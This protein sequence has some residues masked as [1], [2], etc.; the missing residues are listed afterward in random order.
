MIYHARKGQVSYGQP[1]G[2]LLMETQAPFI[3][4]DVGNAYSFSF[5][6]R[7]ETVP[8]LT[9]QKVFD[10]DATGIATLVAAAKK[11]E[12]EGVQAITGDCGFMAYYQRYVME[13]VE[14]PVF[15]S[16]LLQ[17]SFIDLL[18]PPRK[19]IGI[20]TANAPLLNASL[21][22]AVGLTINEERLV[23]RGMQESPSFSAAFL[24][25]TGTLDSTEVERDVVAVAKQLVHD[26]P[27]VGAVLLECSDLPP[28][29][30]KVHEAIHRP[31]F[32][33]ITMINYVQSTVTKQVFEGNL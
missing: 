5:P 6:V 24:Q 12:H 28:Y 20:V 10:R 14:V 25:E 18:L 11:L 2:I 26:D 1:I 33:Y 31:V 21:L 3:P 29:A 19:K 22:Q 4:G 9:A 32:D 30:N 23:I 27:S 17:L 13:E 8:G 15:L 7:Y 16:S